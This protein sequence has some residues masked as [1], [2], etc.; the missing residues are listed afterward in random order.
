MTRSGRRGP[1]PR[2]QAAPELADGIR[3]SRTLR[4]SPRASAARPGAHWFPERKR[5]GRCGRVPVR[6]ANVGGLD[7]RRDRLRQSSPPGLPMDPCS[8]LRSGWDDTEREA[9]EEALNASAG[10]QWPTALRFAS[11]GMTRSGRRGPL[12]RAQV[13]P[14]LADGIRASRTLRPSP[15]ASAARP[16]A[17]WF[18][19]RKRWGRCGRVPVR[20]AYVGVL[21]ARR[22]RLRQSPPPGLP[23]DPCPPL[24]SGWDDTEREA[25]AHAVRPSPNPTSQT[26]MGGPR[27]AHSYLFEDRTS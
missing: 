22:D 6:A 13:A 10:G 18:P 24:R 23:M 15:R 21:D 19:E 9:S 4:P 26:Q 27:A 14:E 12:P 2:A 7:A 8:P 20:A 25:R 1:L 17:H 3:A 16:G 11:A 5:W